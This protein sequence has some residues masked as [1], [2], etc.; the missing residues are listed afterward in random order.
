MKK[1]KPLLIIWIAI[2]PAITGILLVFGDILNQ[3]PVTIRTLVLTLILV[4]LMVYVLVPFWTKV[5]K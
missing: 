4:P 3:L 2:Y 1:L 5:F